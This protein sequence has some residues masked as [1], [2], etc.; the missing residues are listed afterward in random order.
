[1]PKF[2]DFD[3]YFAIDMLKIPASWLSLQDMWGALFVLVMPSVYMVKFNDIEY[4]RLFL[5]A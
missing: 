3:Y 2:W 4:F 5:A 1:M